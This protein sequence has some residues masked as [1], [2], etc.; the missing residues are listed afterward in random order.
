MNQYPVYTHEREGKY[1]Y[2]FKCNRT[3]THI[4]ER[5]FDGVLEKE[6]ERM[7]IKPT[8]LACRVCGN[9]IAPK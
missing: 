8:H 9:R 6:F 2:C 7:K 4:E 5:A 3:T 1:M